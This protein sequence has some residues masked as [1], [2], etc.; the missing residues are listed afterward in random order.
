MRAAILSYEVKQRETLIPDLLDP[1]I[2]R[3]YS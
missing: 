1:S 2:L 3:V